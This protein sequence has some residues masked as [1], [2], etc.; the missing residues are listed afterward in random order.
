MRNDAGRWTA[1]SDAERPAR[2]VG[3]VRIRVVAG[4]QQR[5]LS[6]AVADLARVLDLSG[7]VAWPGVAQGSTYGV[8]LRRDRALL[9]NGA[10]LAD[11][12]H[13]DTSIAVSL[14]SD[15][16]SVIEMEGHGALG[17]LQR[18][19]ELC[20]NEPSGSVAR[21]FHGYPVVLYAHTHANRFRFHVSA[22]MLEG[23]WGLL[24]DL[25]TKSESG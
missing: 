21:R 5:L 11:G 20:S 18:G 9:I 24:V 7:L 6:G 8:R 4:L 16:Y 3:S 19:A 14:V 22:P 1:F 2:A 17:V 13:A 15:A 25:A 23:F 12:W 10:E